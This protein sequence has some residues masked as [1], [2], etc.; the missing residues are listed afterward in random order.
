MKAA[1]SGRGAWT[2]AH[3]RP[4]RWARSPRTPIA[5]DAQA[6]TPEPGAPTTRQRVRRAYLAA[7]TWA[8]VL[9]TTARLLAYAP[10]VLAILQ[11]RNSSQHSLWTWLIWLGANVTMAAWL[12]E[13][14]GQRL[15]KAV[16]VSLSNAVACGLT[17]LAILWF[18]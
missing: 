16:A 15:D 18:R 2:C 3:G 13:H 5:T 11:T 12:Y 9:F 14:N 1:D 7:L 8:F 4:R 10:T 17:S 6:R